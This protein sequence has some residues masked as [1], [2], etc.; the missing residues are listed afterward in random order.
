MSVATKK[1]SEQCYPAAGVS[2]ADIVTRRTSPYVLASEASR[3]VA[4][5]TTEAATVG[6]TATVSLLQATDAAGSGAKD[7]G[8]AVVKTSASGA[9]K[10]LGMAEAGPNDMDHA[11]G[12]L[13]VA[14]TVISNDTS[15]LV[16]SVQ[17][18]LGGL[19]HGVP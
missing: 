9:Q 13:Y 8:T 17:L 6:K 16:G 4:S 12:F 3:I 7:L 14:A 5:M 15:P 11:N 10:L 1:L 2:N 18:I 19:R